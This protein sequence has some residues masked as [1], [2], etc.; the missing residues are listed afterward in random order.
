MVILTTAPISVAVGEQ[1]NY[2]FLLSQGYHANSLDN[3]TDSMMQK[4][5]DAIGDNYV[6]DIEVKKYT[7]F[8]SAGL[9]RG[10]I[11]RDNLSFD[12]AVS[13]VAN[14]HTNYI[15]GVY[16]TLSWEW[17]ANKPLYRG[18]DAIT[19]NWDK[20]VF[21]FGTFVSYDLYKSNAGD[22]WSV[23]RE[24]PDAAEVIQGGIGY[25]TDLKAFVKY[26][27]GN[28]LIVLVPKSPI[29]V[30]TTLSTNINALYAHETSAISG[31]GL[32]ILDFGVSVSWLYEGDTLP[33]P[34]LYHYSQ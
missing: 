32:T 17:V 1:S 3:L 21:S 24:V 8:N 19:L 28:S 33:A 15:T 25:Y 9:T 31:L 26:V 6:A 2:D 20:D 18:Q 5:V 16:I 12:I 13:T 29:T 14:I 4:M 11:D 7:G 34:H 30:G 27:G 23:F 22:D 10:T